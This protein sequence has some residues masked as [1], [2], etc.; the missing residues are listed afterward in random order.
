MAWS[1]LSLRVTRRGSPTLRVIG[2]LVRPSRLGWPL[3]QTRWEPQ[4][5]MGISGTSADCAIRTAPLLKSLSSNAREMVA[6]GKTPTISPALSA[7]T[8]ARKEDA[9]APRSTGMWCMPR[10][11]GPPTPWWNTCSLAMNR[12]RRFAGRAAS[13][14]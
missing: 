6:S 5:A 13:P 10:I 12:T 1:A 9:P 8:A 2:V 7:C 14:A 11:S 3:V 4:I